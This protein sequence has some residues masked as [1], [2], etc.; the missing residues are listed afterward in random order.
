MPEPDVG[1]WLQTSR[2][3]ILPYRRI[4]QSGVASLAK[5]AG[6]PMAV[7]TVGSLAELTR[8]DLTFP[9]GD[10]PA[11]AAVLER[12]LIAAPERDDAVDEEAAPD[13]VDITVDRHHK[14]YA[15]MLAGRSEKTVERAPVG[16][17]GA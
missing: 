15:A 14:L 12:C 1:G 7:S 3:A 13:S 6:L 10:V 2:L 9:P 11:L 5:A 8:P 4:E 17:P 16:A